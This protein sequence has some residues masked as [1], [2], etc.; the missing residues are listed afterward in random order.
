MGFFV[1]P[2]T[3]RC[4]FS[5][6]LADFSKLN[7]FMHGFRPTIA[8]AHHGTSIAGVVLVMGGTP[9]SLEVTL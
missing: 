9:P 4:S 8:R 1:F 6:F 3:F 7:T 2:L 5:R